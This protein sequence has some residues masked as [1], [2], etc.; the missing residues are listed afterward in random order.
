MS[1]DVYLQK[2]MCTHCNHT[3]EADYEFNLT[4]NVNSIV[5]ECLVAG[6]ATEGKD[7]NRHAS[8]SWSRLAGWKGG[9]LVEILAKAQAHAL[10]KANEERLRATEPSNKWG[11]LESVQYCLGNLL[12]QCKEFP[13]SVIR[14]SG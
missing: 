8:R 14:V 7:G 4:H 12:A 10:D 13:D 1:F 5:D 2:P 6:G 3:P 11:T 9:E